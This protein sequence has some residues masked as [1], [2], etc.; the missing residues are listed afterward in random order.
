MSRGRGFSS[1]R[2]GGYRGNSSRGSNSWSSGGNRGGY[3]GHGG[4][5]SG[6]FTSSFSNSLDSRNSFDS[7]NKY[8]GSSDRFSRTHSDDYHKPYRPVSFVQIL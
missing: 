6:R 8:S 4:S 5:S 1:P 2:G 7:R 3:A